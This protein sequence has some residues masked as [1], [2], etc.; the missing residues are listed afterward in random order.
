MR[1][2]NAAEMKEI[3][4]RANANGLSYYDMMENAGGKVAE[5]IKNNTKNFESKLILICTGKGNNGGDG[6]VAARKLKEMGG[7]PLIMLVDGVPKTDDAVKN[8]KIAQDIGLEI[9]SFDKEK[10]RPIIWGCDV[11]VDCIYGTGFREE[12]KQEV[13]EL[14]SIIN[15]SDGIKFSVD[16]PSG[17]RDDGSVAA[18]A[19]R[20]DYTIAVDSLKN[21]HVS[22]AASE[23]CGKV[24]CVDI[25][26]PEECH[27]L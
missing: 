3:E 14:F 6:F 25:G 20:A 11:I 9:I 21:A 16:M 4:K 8:F 17:V 24:V 27:N 7:N 1:I 18:G 5:F 23:N 15:E 26:I 13:A 2:V 19:F 12:L 10:S 22:A